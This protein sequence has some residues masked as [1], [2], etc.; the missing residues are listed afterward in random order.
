MQKRAAFTLVEL[1]VVIAVI[2]ALIALLMPAI[3][4]S[5]EAARLAKCQSNLHE[6]G[7]AVF[8]YT[9]RQGVNGRLPKTITD[10]ADEYESNAGILICP[11]DTRLHELAAIPPGYLSYG[12]HVG[13]RT[14]IQLYEE[15][16]LPSAKIAVAF[17][18]QSFHGPVG[19]EESQPAIF[20]DG[21]VGYYA[22]GKR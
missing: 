4:A 11:S 16:Q 20:L 1:L 18:P 3:H 12:Y 9:D 8:H 6:I 19:E 15:Y 13:G 7:I 22:S 14:R 10:A 17:D 21:H 5:R 2:A